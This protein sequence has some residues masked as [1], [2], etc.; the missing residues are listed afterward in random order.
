AGVRV[1][2]PLSSPSGLDAPGPGRGGRPGPR[3]GAARARGC[4]QNA[5]PG[6][7]HADDSR[8]LSRRTVANLEAPGLLHL[9]ARP[10]KLVDESPVLGVSGEGADVGEGSEAQR[11]EDV[12][13]LRR[14]GVGGYARVR[15]EHARQ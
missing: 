8:L 3:G 14:I 5:G 10:E 7:P 6:E 2:S 4:E 9:D 15:A 12:P 1:V 13:R 11:D